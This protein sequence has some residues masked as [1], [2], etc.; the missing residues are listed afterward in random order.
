LVIGISGSSRLGLDDEAKMRRSQKG[1]TLIEVVVTLALIAI[2]IPTMFAALSAAIT[3]A[4]RIRDRSIVLELAQSQ[5]ESIQGQ[6]FQPGRG[7][8]IIPHPA[9]FD[10]DVVID[11]VERCPRGEVILQR[12]TITVTGRHGSLQLEGYKVRR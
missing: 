5:M 4:D 12:V 11:C 6:E 3:S 7:Y 10:V 2:L 8:D 1:Q 9:G